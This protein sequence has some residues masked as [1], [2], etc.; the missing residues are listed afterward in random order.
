MRVVVPDMALMEQVLADLWT[1]L[2]DYP[3]LSLD[4]RTDLA[5]ADVVD[6]RINVGR[7]Y[8]PL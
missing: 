2:A 6:E 4:W 5:L 3:E 7:F 8:V 1:E